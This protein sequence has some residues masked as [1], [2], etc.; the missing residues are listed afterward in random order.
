MME[1]LFWY[2]VIGIL[3][4]TAIALCDEPRCPAW[5]KWMIVLPLT[6]FAWP[7]FAGVLLFRLLEL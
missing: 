6:L 4:A 2:V 5:I 3:F 7:V 1:C